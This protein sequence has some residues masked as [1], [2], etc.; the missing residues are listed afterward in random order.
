MPLLDE[1]IS[2]VLRFKVAVRELRVALNL[3]QRLDLS[4]MAASVYGQAARKRKRTTGDAFEH[5]GARCEK[6][7]D[8]VDF[9][10]AARQK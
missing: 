7:L 9:V 3:Q 2:E 8:R 1:P 10:S 4:E 6:S 5:V